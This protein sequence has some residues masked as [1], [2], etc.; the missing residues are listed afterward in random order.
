MPVRRMLVTESVFDETEALA[1][2]RRKPSV[3]EAACSVMV[4][5]IARYPEHEHVFTCNWDPSTQTITA[6]ELLVRGMRDQAFAMAA[7]FPP[8]AMAVHNHPTGQVEPS[9]KD[10]DCAQMLAGHGIG[11]AIVNNLASEVFVV[12][13]PRMTYEWYQP[14][15]RAMKSWQLGRAVFTWMGPKA[16]RGPLASLPVE[17]KG[18]SQ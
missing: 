12:R 5:A 16:D 15:P 9:T 8:N 10:L 2:L 1:R 11:F 3:S 18:V 13:E 14:K 17:K 4:A 6:A 7:D